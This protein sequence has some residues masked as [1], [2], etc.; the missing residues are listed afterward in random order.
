LRRLLKVKRKM[1]GGR[2]TLREGRMRM[3]NLIRAWKSLSQT[4]IKIRN[5]NLQSKWSKKL[6]NQRKTLEMTSKKK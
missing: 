2:R 3:P 1:M 5:K 6:K 4:Q